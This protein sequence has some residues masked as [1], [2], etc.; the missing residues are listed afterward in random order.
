[1]LIQ[2]EDIAMAAL[3]LG[4]A[5][6]TIIS[7]ARFW[8]RRLEIRDRARTGAGE[9]D[10]RLLRIEQAVDAIAIEVERV[11]EAQRFTTKMLAERLPA[12]ALPS[13]ASRRSPS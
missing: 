2:G 9:M 6:A 11:S 3:I 13:E 8:F 10:D 4:T 12:V 7:L 5:S 1:M